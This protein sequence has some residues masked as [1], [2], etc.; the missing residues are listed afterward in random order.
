MVAHDEGVGLGDGGVGRLRSGSQRGGS[1][2]HG[3][4]FIL[5]AAEMTRDALETTAVHLAETVLADGHGTESFGLQETRDAVEGVVAD[6]ERLQLGVNGEVEESDV[7]EGVVEDVQLR[8]IV[9]D[10]GQVLLGVD[11]LHD[12]RGVLVGEVVGFHRDGGGADRSEGKCET[13]QLDTDFIVVGSVATRVHF[14]VGVVTVHCVSCE[15]SGNGRSIVRSA[16]GLC[17]IFGVE[18]VG[19][20]V[21][22]HFN[23]NRCGTNG[24]SQVAVAAGADNIVARNAVLLT[25]SAMGIVI[26]NF[27]YAHT[28]N[29][30]QN[31]F[32][33]GVSIL[34]SPHSGFQIIYREESLVI[35]PRS[36]SYGK[37]W[38]VVEI[39]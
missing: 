13:V 20:G 22:A 28:Y 34:R 19:V 15:D 1:G 30:I 25:S 24:S 2:H 10:V 29:V 9:G 4:L 39:G 3:I 17:G 12:V 23:I 5:L 35:S 36:E 27:A 11:V 8:H 37:I 14:P 6:D 32:R 26:G 18:L 7:V 21:H 16:Q 38:I 31:I 33:R